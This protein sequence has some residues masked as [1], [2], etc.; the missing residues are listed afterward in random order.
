MV[1]PPLFNGYVRGGVVLLFG[2]DDCF[3]RRV[4]NY[5]VAFARGLIMSVNWMLVAVVVAAYVIG[6]KFPGLA[7]RFI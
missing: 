2:S 7:N 1:E 3:S 4:E 6:A 5:F